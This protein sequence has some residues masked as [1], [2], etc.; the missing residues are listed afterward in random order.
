MNTFLSSAFSCLSVLG[1]MEFV[2]DCDSC[3]LDSS[4]LSLSA[5]VCMVCE[6]IIE[7]Q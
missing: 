3:T 6:G 1:V 4:A 7:S 2:G 5:L